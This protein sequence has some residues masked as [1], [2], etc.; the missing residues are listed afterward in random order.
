MKNANSRPLIDLPWRHVLLLTCAL[1]FAASIY[2]LMIGAGAEAGV[3]RGAALTSLYLGFCI[4]QRRL[5][6]PARRYVDS[7]PRERFIK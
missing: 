5:F 6:T 3:W 4:T 1:L 2:K 7:L